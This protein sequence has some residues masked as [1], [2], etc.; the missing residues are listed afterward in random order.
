MHIRQGCLL[1][2]CVVS[3]GVTCCPHLDET[4]AA[5]ALRESVQIIAIRRIAEDPIDLLQALRL[6]TEPPTVV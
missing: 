6:V 3:T 2:T 4:R 5:R 1:G